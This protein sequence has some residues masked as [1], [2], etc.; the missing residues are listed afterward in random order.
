MW[1][2]RPFSPPVH[3]IC[4]TP[5]N[6]PITDF[7]LN[8]LNIPV[9]SGKQYV[10]E[11]VADGTVTTST[12]ATL[13]FAPA[14]TTTGALGFV[15]SNDTHSVSVASHSGDWGNLIAWV[16]TDTTGTNQDG[17]INWAYEVNPQAAAALTIGQT[18]TDTFTVTLI[19]S[20][21]Q[22]GDARRDCD[23]HRHQRGCRS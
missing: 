14:L 22:P 17:K 15:D 20:A 18:H 1:S 16:S 4:R 12:P 7:P 5:T 8:G 21:R 10:W 11:I 9:D 3:L 2:V 19:D 6:T 13:N 23:G